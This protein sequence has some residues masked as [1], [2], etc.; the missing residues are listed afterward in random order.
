ML[1]TLDT[2]RPNVLVTLE[3]LLSLA[4]TIIVKSNRLVV[5]RDHTNR[6]YDIAT[7]IY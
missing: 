1:Q 6:V 3:Y 2:L 4:H 7:I 5:L